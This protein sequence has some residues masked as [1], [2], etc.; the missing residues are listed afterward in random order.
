MLNR[1]CA[2]FGDTTISLK[3]VDVLVNT[4]EK[5]GLDK[6]GEIARRGVSFTA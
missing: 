2:K 4:Y 6:D 3:G 5:Y 1:H